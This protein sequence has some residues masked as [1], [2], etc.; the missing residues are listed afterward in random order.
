MGEAMPKDNQVRELFEWVQ[1]EVDRGRPVGVISSEIGMRAVESGLN[2]T[3]HRNPSIDS[4]R[5]TFEG[6]HLVIRYDEE[7]WLLE[8]PD[9]QSVPQLPASG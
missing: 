7:R 5:V 4:L 6:T 2:A 3:T 8:P 9:G 1:R